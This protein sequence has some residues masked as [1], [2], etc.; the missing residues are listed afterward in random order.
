MILVSIGYL[1]IISLDSSD[2]SVVSTQNEGTYLNPIS[3]Q[4]LK[5]QSS[6]GKSIITRAAAKELKVKP[7]KFFVFNI[8]PFNEITLNKVTIAFYKNEYGPS[9]ID[10]K[11]LMHKLIA[12]KDDNSPFSGRHPFGAAKTG[13]ITRGIINHFILKIYDQ[14]NLSLMI[15]SAKA[16]LNFK[17]GEVV[18]QDAMVEDFASK[19]I[20]N[21]RKIVF[22]SG[23]NVLRVPGQYVLLSQ[24]GSKQGNGLKI[25]L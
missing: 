23:E 9:E 1:F 3:I 18:F 15:K 4:G 16:Y 17:K 24:T 12:G 22:R 25:N 19:K 2:Q 11:E 7:R 10:L 21:S 5:F 14:N 8:R 13:L 20:I 6:V